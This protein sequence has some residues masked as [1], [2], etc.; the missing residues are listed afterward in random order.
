MK[1]FLFP[2]V[3]ILILALTVP[4][5]A[6]AQQTFQKFWSAIFEDGDL[7]LAFEMLSNEDQEFIKTQTPEVYGFL[8]GE[9]RED[10]GEVGAIVTSLQDLIFSTMG[11]LLKLDSQIGGKNEM[12]TEVLY[13]VSIPTGSD[14]ISEIVTWAK[15]KQEQFEGADMTDPIKAIADAIKELSG[16]LDRA[17]YKES[18]S[19]N[20]FVT[21]VKEDGKEK[22][23]L[24]LRE[25]FAKMQKLGMDLESM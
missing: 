16:I 1:K 11:K 13:S 9:N 15:A 24:N 20:S 2:L 7:K 10:L 19:F 6:E 4:S 3:F 8:I 14:F 12:G 25:D 17:D 22:L 21:I 18:I 23:A 5:F